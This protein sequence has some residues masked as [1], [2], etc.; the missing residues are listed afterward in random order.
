M[1]T[2]GVVLSLLSFTVSPDHKSPWSSSVLLTTGLTLI[3]VNFVF[4]RAFQSTN[5]G[6]LNRAIEEYNSRHQPQIY[7]GPNKNDSTYI[8]NDLHFGFAFSKDF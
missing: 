3:V 8:P 5:E 2:T 1:G 4:N 7:F 6:N